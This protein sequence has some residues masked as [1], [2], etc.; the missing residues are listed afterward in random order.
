MMS[1][2]EPAAAAPTPGFLVYD[3]LAGVDA[4]VAHLHAANTMDI[5]ETER[6]GVAGVF[7]K[8]LA[9]RMGIPAQRM[10]ALLGV[11][12]A[13]AEKKA[14]GGETLSG[15]GGR[16]ALGVARLLGLARELVEQSTAPEA[17]GFDSAR[18]LSVWL[19]TPQ[20][21]LGGRKPVDLLDTPTGYE[22]VARLLGSLESGAYA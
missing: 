6:Q 13:T 5:I 22:V 14:L 4:F 20:P 12:K 16:A 15:G 18:W 1:R 11:P 9:R 19:D 21:A 10:F 7:V 2:P 8:D 3:P 17:A